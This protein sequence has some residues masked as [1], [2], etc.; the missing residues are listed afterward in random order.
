[1]ERHSRS[2][3]DVNLERGRYKKLNKIEN[4]GISLALVLATA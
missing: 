4:A 3:P 1:M 2:D